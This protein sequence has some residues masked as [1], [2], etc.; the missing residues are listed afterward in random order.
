[1]L[2]RLV[3]HRRFPKN[4]KSILNGDLDSSHNEAQYISLA[5][6]RTSLISITIA[7]TNITTEVWEN[8]LERGQRGLPSSA[9][10]KCYGKS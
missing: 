4:R 7:L 2:G 1:M 8:V 9:G 3:R 5:S 10:S 6:G